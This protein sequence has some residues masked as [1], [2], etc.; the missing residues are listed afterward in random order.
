MSLAGVVAMG[1]RALGQHSVGKARALPW[2]R[3][4]VPPQTCATCLVTTAG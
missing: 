4:G 1:W 2:T 3:W